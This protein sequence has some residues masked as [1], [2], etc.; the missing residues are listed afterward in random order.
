VEHVEMLIVG[1][2]IPE[3]ANGLIEAM[4]AKESQCNYLHVTL[5]NDDVSDSLDY[6]CISCQSTWEDRDCV[7]EHIINDTRTFFCLNCDDWVSKKD[8]DLNQGW[9]L[10]D[11]N[12]FIFKMKTK[13][14]CKIL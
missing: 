11:G 5:A 3:F 9:T 8:E 6:K 13:K 14:H 12:G 4:G 2:D 1:T 7:V 10:L